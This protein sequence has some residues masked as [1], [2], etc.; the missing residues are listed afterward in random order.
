MK[1]IIA[2]ILASL[3]AWIG[4]RAALKLG[5]VRAIVVISPLIEEI[6]KTGMALL[7]GGSLILTHGVFGLV[8][9]LYD[10]WNSGTEG[11][12]A[13]AVSFAGHLFY[14]YTAFQVLHKFGIIPAVIAG[15][16]VHMLWNLTVL[17]FIVKKKH[18]T[19][20]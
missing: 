3:G 18:R 10:V 13:G 14:G 19:L 12:K 8:E 17:K 16:V 4:N 6:A 11:V 20:V 7:T 5:G 9:G 1:F 15:Y 2:G